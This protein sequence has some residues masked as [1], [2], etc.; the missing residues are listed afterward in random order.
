MQN[1]E[2]ILG[3]Q[4]SQLNQLVSFGSLGSQFGVKLNKLFALISRKYLKKLTI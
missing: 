3:N 2:R 1:D 4:K